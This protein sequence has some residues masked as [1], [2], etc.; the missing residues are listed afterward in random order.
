MWA[1]F[2]A[3][4]A[5]ITL[6]KN[7]PRSVTHEY[8]RAAGLWWQG[9]PIYTDGAHGFLYLP[10]AAMAFTPFTWLPNAPREIVWRCAG[11]ALL[12]FGVRRLSGL[13]FMAFKDAAFL[14]ATPLV[15]V[16]AL[17]SAANGQTNI[18]LAG[19]FALCFADLIDKRWSRVAIWLMLALACKPTAVVMVL[20]VGAVYIRPMWWRLGVAIA[21]FAL[22]PFA[23]PN[24]A[25]VGGQYQD[26]LA[27]LAAA[28]QPGDS[29][30]DF[31]GLLIE[32]GL[33]HVERVAATSRHA[34]S[35]V[36]TP[37]EAV[38]TVVRVVA[39]LLTLALVV[40]ASRRFRDVGR[41]V[42]LYTLGAIYLT[43]FNPRTEGLGYILLGVPAAMWA[44]RELHHRRWAAAVFFIFFALSTQLSTQIA[45]NHK[46]YWVRPL[47]AAV[48]AALVMVEIARSR[49]RWDE[50]PGST[51]PSATG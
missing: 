18:H 20:L 4:I 21:V 27:K 32:F 3:G 13:L 23:H 12:V 50:H 38:L 40:I 42:I 6:L 2:A 8:G 37:P 33:V 35:I 43:L 5:A 14:I 7:D 46:N 39:A 26:C 15:I 9:Q 36:Q 25:Y 17:G 51:T 34:G 49:S 41:A 10:Q 47:G 22:L 30:Q 11:L 16:S 44:V 1:L 45:M 31:R 19:L 24:P 28:S 29:F 48:F